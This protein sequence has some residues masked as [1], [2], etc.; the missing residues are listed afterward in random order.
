MELKKERNKNKR[1]KHVEN[2]ITSKGNTTNVTTKK[3]S[4]KTNKSVFGPKNKDI[5]KDLLELKTTVKNSKIKTDL[6]DLKKDLSKSKNT[7]KNN[8]NKDKQYYDYDDIEYK[9]KEI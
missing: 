9:G 4:K 7:T 5:I 6:T 1:R 8:K 2:L 3:V